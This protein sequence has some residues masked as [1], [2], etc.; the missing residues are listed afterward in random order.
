MDWSRIAAADRLLIEAD[1]WPIQGERFQ[2]TGFPEIGPA[3]YRLADGTPMLLVESPQSIANRLEAVCWDFGRDDLVNVL[4]G[5]PYVRVVMD[6]QFLTSSILEAHRLN[7]GYILG[8]ESSSFLEILK[9]EFQDFDHRPVDLRVM[10]KTALR[11]D[12]NSLVHGLFL[13]RPDL[14]GGRLRLPRMLSGFIEAREA[15]AVEEGGVKND[16]VLPTGNTGKGFGNVP[17]ARTEFVADQITAYFNL[18][19]RLMRSYDLG[20]AAERFLVGL[21]LWKIRCFLEDGLRLRT[22]C[23]LVCREVRVTRPGGFDLPE[24]AELDELLPELIDAVEAF[25]RPPVTEVEFVPPG[26]WT[27]QSRRAEES[28]PEERA[29]DEVDGE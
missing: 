26:D 14:A 12:P 15:E 8:G 21:S 27:R 11:Y 25:R 7:S 3:Q 13:A 2:P 23:D 20:E 10:A 16:R 9:Q 17:Y 6:G 28:A 1:L 24:R 29:S 5:M 18:D 19:L 22:A 4:R